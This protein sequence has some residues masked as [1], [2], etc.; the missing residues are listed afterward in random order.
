[1][2]LITFAAPTFCRRTLR[3]SQVTLAKIAKTLVNTALEALAVRVARALLIK[4]QMFSR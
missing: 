1:V 4:A 3:V 2:R